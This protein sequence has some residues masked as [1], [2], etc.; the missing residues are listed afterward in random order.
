MSNRSK[1]FSIGI[2]LGIVLFAAIGVTTW[3]LTTVYASDNCIPRPTSF[4]LQQ[5]ESVINM[6]WSKNINCPSDSYKVYRVS[7]NETRL[8]GHTK[9]TKWH[10]D[11]YPTTGGLSYIVRGVSDGKEHGGVSYTVRDRISTP[12]PTPTQISEDRTLVC[13]Y[14]QAGEIHSVSG[15]RECTISEIN[16]I[17]S[18]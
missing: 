1:I 5:T 17:L 18:K 3:L 14:S 9:N 4:R 15:A 16:H 12:T 11:S 7:G 10:D 13:F 2:V 6:T 8:L